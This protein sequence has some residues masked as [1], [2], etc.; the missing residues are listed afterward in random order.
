MSS[1]EE[2]YFGQLRKL[3]GTRKLLVP[4]VAAFIPDGDGRFLFIRRRD[5]ERWALPAGSMELDETV[6][7]AMKR[8]VLE[9]TGLEVVSAT[10][11][12]VYSGSKLSW[13]NE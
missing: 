4:A 13:T 3:V 1:F 9:E 2:S 8:E 11:V 7:D 10:L 6:Y 5:N 12:A